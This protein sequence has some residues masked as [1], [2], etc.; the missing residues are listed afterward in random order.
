MDSVFPD[1]ATEQQ[2]LEIY[3]PR[4]GMPFTAVTLADGRRR[5]LWT[6][7]TAQQADIDVRHP[8]G[9]AYLRSI[10]DA[11]QRAA[12]AWC[13]S[14]PWATPSRRPAAAAS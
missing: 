5:L 3:R 1:G 11:L 10:L 7:F 9:Q 12:C 14:T 2:L 8:Q 13:G 4:P 6:T